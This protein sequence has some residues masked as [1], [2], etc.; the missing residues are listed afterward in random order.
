MI[1]LEE[2]NEIKVRKRLNSYYAEKEYLQYIFLHALSRHPEH[3]VFKGGT[4]LRICFGLERASEDLDFNANLSIGKIKEIIKKC[5]RDFELLG[6]YYEIYS[7]KEFKGNLRMEIRFQGPLY[8]GGLRSTNTIKIDFNKG[9]VHHTIV[10]VIP[11]LF[12]DVPLF[13]LVVMDEKEILAEKIRA[14]VSRKE[15]RDLYDVWMILSKGVAIDK[16]LIIGKFKAEKILF[17]KLSGLRFPSKEEYE[18]GLKN[19]VFVLPGYEQVIR[20]VLGGL[21]EFKQTPVR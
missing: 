21:E 20:E 1:G 5:L 4:C 13:S 15:P 14:L 16:K 3:F 12:S 18:N 7:E 6:I 10:R 8:Q 17:S 9:K 19:L 11:Q 2:L